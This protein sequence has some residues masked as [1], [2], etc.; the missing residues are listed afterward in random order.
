MSESPEIQVLYI[1]RM[2]NL[3]HTHTHYNYDDDWC[4]CAHVRLNGPSNLQTKSK[5]KHPS[6]SPPQDSNSGGSD[7]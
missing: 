4:F 2:I 5:M 1:T 6:D 7:L 3:T